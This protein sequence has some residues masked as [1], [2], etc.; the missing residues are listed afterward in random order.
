MLKCIFFLQ[1]HSVFLS[2]SQVKLQQDIAYFGIVWVR[3]PVD[4]KA[5]RYVV[6]ENWTKKFKSPISCTQLLTAKHVAGK[7][8]FFCSREIN[9]P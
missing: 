9:Y 5:T 2:A 7:D 4:C 3:Y 8:V 6:W 1:D